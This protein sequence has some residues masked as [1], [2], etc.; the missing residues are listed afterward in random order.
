[1]ITKQDAVDLFELIQGSRDFVVTF[2]Y[3]DGIE[4]FVETVMKWEKDL[5]TRNNEQN[6][7]PKTILQKRSAVEWFAELERIARQR[8]GLSDNWIWKR[9]EWVGHPGKEGL[10]MTLGIAGDASSQILVLFT[11]SD[12]D[13]AR[14]EEKPC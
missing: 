1:L 5:G 4:K 7:K 8:Y 6:Q 11:Q 9:S 2:R 13:A 12:C 10:K 14:W 3:H